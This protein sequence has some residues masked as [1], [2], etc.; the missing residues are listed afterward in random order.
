MI[1]ELDSRRTP[2]RVKGKQ[3][4]TKSLRRLLLRTHRFG[5]CRAVGADLWWT[6]RVIDALTTALDVAEG[7]RGV[8]G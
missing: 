1:P 4:L 8:G 7:D 3:A 6:A 2:G 5:R